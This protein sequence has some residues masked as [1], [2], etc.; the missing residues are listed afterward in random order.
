MPKH[1][2]VWVTL[3]I[4][5]TLF[6][7]N[8]HAAE[9]DQPLRR[10]AFGSCAHQNRPQPIWDQIVAA[11]PDLFLFIGDTIYA[12]TEDMEVMRSEYAKLAAIPGY[13]RL[14]QTSPIMAIWDDHDYGVSDG[15]AEY[16]KRAES[17]QIFLD[18]FG[19]PQDSP[20]RKRPGVYDAH[21]LGPAGKRV[22][23]I[24][25]DTRYFR[26]P[27]KRRPPGPAGAGPYE[28]N[29]DPSA[30]ML[31]EAQWEW[32]AAQLRVPAEV[33]IVV[34]GIQV[35]AEDHGWEKWM[36]LP[37]ERDRLFKLIRETGATGVIL[38]SGDRHLAELSMMDGGVGYPLY[39]LTASGLNVAYKRWRMYETNRHRIATLNK[40]DHFGLITIDWDRADPRISLQIRDDEGEITLQQ[41]IDLS[42]LR[43]GTIP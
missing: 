30:T 34:S 12:D 7:V 15:G 21:V 27:L 22:Q 25:L 4:V 43:P 9:S 38:I 1:S 3:V 33:R 32:L 31:G 42:L 28:P 11:K 16:P 29:P 13:Q 23:V 5:L 10:I 17:Q 18:F 24:L 37:H 20:R 2:T 6:L 35:V 14:R 41:K 40:G 36:N 19:E 39:D 26:G 8:G